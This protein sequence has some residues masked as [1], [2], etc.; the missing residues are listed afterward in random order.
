MSDKIKPLPP[1]K[2]KIN[3]KQIVGVIIYFIIFIISIVSLL[4]AC[5]NILCYYVFLIKNNG[6]LNPETIKY[7]IYIVIGSWFFLILDR[8]KIYELFGIKRD[9]PFITIEQVNNK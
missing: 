4:I 2:V 1:V 8:K 6:W 5:A 9:L 3:W 7:S